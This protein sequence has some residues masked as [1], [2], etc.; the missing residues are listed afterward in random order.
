MRRPSLK[1]RI[2][3][4]ENWN[5]CNPEGT[6]VTVLKDSGEI[7]TTKTRS[8]AY[9]LGASS[10]HPGHTPVILVNGI[11]GCYALDRIRPI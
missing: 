11:S 3:K 4:V 10:S 5:K 6:D 2:A 9:M 7:V 8:K 1:A